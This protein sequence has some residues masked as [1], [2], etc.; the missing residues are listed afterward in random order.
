MVCHYCGRSYAQPAVCPSCGSRDLRPL[1]YGTEKIEEEVLKRFPGSRTARLD[2]DT[3]RSRSAFEKTIE[4]FARGKTDILI[5]TQMVSKGLDFNNVRV[6]GILDADTMLSQPDFRCYERSFQMMSQVAGRAGRRGKRGL[7]ILQT[8]HADYHVIAQIVNNDY[9]AMY[10]EQIAERMKF[11]YPPFNRFIYVYLKHRDEH[12]V[13][14]AAKMLGNMCRQCF[15]DRILG[16]DK[17][18]IGRIQSMYIRKI[19]LKAEQELS[20]RK[21]REALLQMVRT[22]ETMPNHSALQIYFDVDPL[23]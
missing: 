11:H 2:L 14:E 12:V 22:V 5:G 21:V 4:D 23:G 15:G 19:I 9:A 6:V 3:T 1:G 8:K 7:V 20:S 18:I 17:P 13:A 16:P 10:E